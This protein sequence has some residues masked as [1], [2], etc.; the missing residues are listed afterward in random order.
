MHGVK[1][2]SEKQLLEKKK[3]D[4]QRIKLY[5]DNLDEVL[6]R[7][8]NNHLDLQTLELVEK[9]ISMNTF[10]YTMWNFRRAIL[11]NLFSQQEFDKEKQLE[12][13]LTFIQ[14]TLQMNPKCYSIWHHRQW[15]LEQQNQANW[16]RELFLCKKLLTVDQRN[17][18]CWNYRR[19]ILKKA[20]KKDEEDR[21]YTSQKIEENFS[22]YSS[23]HQRI[24][25]STNLYNNDY[26]NFLKNELDYVHSAF[27][28]EPNDQSTWFYFRWLIEKAPKE[29]LEE[30][31][32]TIE[33]L[34]SLDPTLS[35][36]KWPILTLVFLFKKLNLSSEVSKPH[37]EKLISV[38]PFR[39]NYYLSLL[40]KI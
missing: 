28:T 18:H 3:E 40:E 13:E 17:F 27:Y 36:S 19:W 34:I 23:W 29:T 31:V 21:E 2:L 1:K 22:N 6:K 35:S 24:I 37:I 32:K 15:T 11:L 5:R 10:H 30:E 14:K 9:V 38:D 12:I 7:K 20:N 8:C 25:C 39:K 33:E 16:E 4:E 26:E